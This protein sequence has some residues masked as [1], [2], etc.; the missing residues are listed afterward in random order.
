VTVPVLWT[1]LRLG[2]EHPAVCAGRGNKLPVCLRNGGWYQG[3][4]AA[5]ERV[6]ASKHLTNVHLYTCA[7]SPVAQQL[8][9]V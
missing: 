9:L 3:T 1:S 2:A 8:D 5:A 4:P 7:G 6:G